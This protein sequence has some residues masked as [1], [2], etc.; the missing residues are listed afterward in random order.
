MSGRN[1][2]IPPGF[3]IQPILQNSARPPTSQARPV[4]AGGVGGVLETA[5]GG[6]SKQS[7][8]SE[9]IFNHQ[10]HFQSK[11]GIFFQ[12]N[13]RGRAFFRI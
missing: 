7:L 6:Y 1:G 3:N 5:Q 4:T 11:K 13:S 9:V 10:K 2:P 8:D 12:L